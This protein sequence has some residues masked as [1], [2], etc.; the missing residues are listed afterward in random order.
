MSYTFA[1]D[2]RK[3]SDAEVHDSVRVYYSITVFNIRELAD[4]DVDRE[5]GP[6]SNKI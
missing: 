2:S 1:L 3:H 6:E 5:D 4:D